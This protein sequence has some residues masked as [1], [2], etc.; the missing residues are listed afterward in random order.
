MIDRFQISL[1]PKLPHTPENQFQYRLINEAEERV[2]PPE[3]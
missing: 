2:Q 1:P 3:G